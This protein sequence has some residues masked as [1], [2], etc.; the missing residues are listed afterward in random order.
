V[1]PQEFAAKWTDVADGFRRRR[2]L[3]DGA[4]LLDDVLADVAAVAQADADE[5]LDLR[6][7]ARE[8]GYSADHLGRLVHAGT[9]PNAGRP[10]APRIRRADLPRKARLRRSTDHRTLVSATSRQSRGLSSPPK[11]GARR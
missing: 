1:T 8:S 7:A 11:N 3:V 10:H 2:A 6:A 4:A 9:I 5:L